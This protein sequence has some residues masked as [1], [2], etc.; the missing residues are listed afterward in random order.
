MKLLKRL[1]FAFKY[2]IDQ[3]FIVYSIPDQMAIRFLKYEDAKAFTDK[4][5]EYRP[6][7]MVG[8][9]PQGKIQ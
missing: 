1:M 3:E 6:K 4:Q 9:R 7:I 5:I 2:D 8:V